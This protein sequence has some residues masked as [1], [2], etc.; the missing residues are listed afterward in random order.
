MTRITRRRLSHR[1]EVTNV[2][3]DE[4]KA[5]SRIRI[6][7]DGFVEV[8]AIPG[9]KVVEADHMLPKTEQL[10][11]EVGSDETG[12]TGHEPHPPVCDELATDFV[13]SRATRKVRH[14]GITGSQVT[15]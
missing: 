5:A 15:G 9:R 14:L 8:G 13:V 1:F 4:S 7:R 12:R 10:L 3:L 6:R 2:A 11:N